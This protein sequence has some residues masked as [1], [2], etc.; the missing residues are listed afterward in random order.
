MVLGPREGPEPLRRGK[1]RSP[2]NAQAVHRWRPVALATWD[3]T[4]HGP[5]WRSIKGVKPDALKGAS[6]VLN[7]GDEET[8]LSRPRLVATQLEC[9]ISSTSSKR[10]ERRRWTS[11]ARGLPRV[12]GAWPA[13][14]AF[15]V[16]SASGTWRPHI[17]PTDVSQSLVGLVI[18]ALGA[19]TRLICLLSRGCRR[20][21]ASWHARAAFI[22]RRPGL[23]SPP[24]QSAQ[25]GSLRAWWPGTSGCG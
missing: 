23:F 15:R 20:S 17:C 12:H 4:L 16:N 9:G 19:S 18:A 6:P 5:P 2:V 7:G 8:G 11:S 25:A 1:P 13:T 14:A 3:P 24:R 22:Q 21:S 10:A